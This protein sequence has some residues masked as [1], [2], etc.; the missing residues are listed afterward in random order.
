M[1]ARSGPGSTYPK[2]WRTPT[3]PG[4][5]TT[6]V[7]PVA[8]RTAIGPGRWARTA[9]AERR[10]ENAMTS[11]T[12]APTSLPMAAPRGETPRRYVARRGTAY[13]KRFGP[14]VPGSLRLCA[15]ADVAQLLVARDPLLGHQPLEHQLARRDHGAR[16]LL[17]GEAH[18]VHQVEQAG[19]DAEALE[20]ALRALVHGDLE[21][22]TFVE[23]VDNVVHVGAAHPG[24]ERLAGGASDQV[25]RDRFGT[26]Q[27][28]LVLEL[29]L[30]RDRGQRGV[31][32]RDAR[33]HRFFLGGDGAT[34]RVRHHVL[35]HADR[36]A[37]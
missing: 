25:L 18:L 26:L 6:M 15:C 1:P 16:V 5:I 33:D 21:R 19:H 2:A 31:D 13:W 20:A 24:L 10:R 28:A 23:P 29:E 11:R 30:A 27:L 32:V 35:Q 12:P 36:E 3:S 9:A 14:P 4:S 8:S 22:P 7:D 17:G 37:L 34:L